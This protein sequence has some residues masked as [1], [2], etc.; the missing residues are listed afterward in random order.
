MLGLIVGTKSEGYSRV[1]D[2][3]QSSGEDGGELIWEEGE[4]RAGG[5]EGP[6]EDSSNVLSSGVDGGD[7]ERRW[8]I[9]RALPFEFLPLTEDCPP[10]LGS[11]AMKRSCSS[12]DPGA[13]STLEPLA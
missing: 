2:C 7:S 10:W 8:A 4:E 1:G 3:S 5:V 13:D 6:G 9:A 11:A 12:T